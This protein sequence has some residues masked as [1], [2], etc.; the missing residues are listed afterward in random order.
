MKAKPAAIKHNDVITPV[1]YTKKRGG[2]NGWTWHNS[3]WPEHQHKL[4]CV[5]PDGSQ[6]VIYSHMY[7][8]HKLQDT[9]LLK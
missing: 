7:R 2:W 6:E 4:H 5:V 1:P 9:G 8:I 3:K